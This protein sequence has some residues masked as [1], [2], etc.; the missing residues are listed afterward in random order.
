MERLYFIHTKRVKNKNSCGQRHIPD[1]EGRGNS[2]D[3]GIFI[4]AIVPRH[5]ETVV[6]LSQRRA[7]EHIDIKLDLTDLD[8]TAAEAKATY[9]EI[10]EYVNERYGIK[11]PSLYISQVKRKLGFKVTDSFNKPK[12][13]NAK[14]PQCPPDKEKIIVEALKYFK[15]I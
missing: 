15:M 2:V 6:L 7:D 5:V 8:L 10:K 9:E 3:N 4:H 14:Q 11:V 13:E 12:T 1:V